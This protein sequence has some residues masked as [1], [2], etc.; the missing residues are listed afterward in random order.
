M[1]EEELI[2]KVVEWGE[3]K[4]I[5]S[6]STPSKQLV[7]TMEESLE[8]IVAHDKGDIPEII[9]AI[10]DIT[11]TYILYLALI[12]L[13]PVKVIPDRVSIIDTAPD[14]F[15]SPVHFDLPTSMSVIDVP[16]DLFN[17]ER[18]DEVDKEEIP[19]SLWD[20]V[21]TYKVYA[22]ASIL[23]RLDI[24]A[25]SIGTNLHDCLLEAYKVISQRTGKMVDGLFVKD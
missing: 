17:V 4:G 15:E 12:N 16:S 13:D 2:L 18:I 21:N 23:H 10:G 19:K 3:E 24:E 7:K 14:E 22:I 8:F 11:V 20:I 5:L 9:D 1:T 6:N 25:K